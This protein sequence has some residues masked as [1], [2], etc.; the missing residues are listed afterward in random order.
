[1]PRRPEG[2]R[3]Y[4]REKSGQK[5][6]WEIR[7]A[8]GIRL[9]TG[10]RCREEAEAQLA[11]Y[12]E[13]KSRPTGPVN[14]DELS[15]SLC[16]SIYAEEHA[17]FVAAPERIGYAIEALDEFWR[18]LPVSSVTGAMC[19]RYAATRQRRFRDGRT[20][21]V[22]PGTIRR[23]LNVLQ[24]AINHCHGEGYLITAPKVTLP[25]RPDPV[26]RF[27]TRQEA[28]WLIRAAR[29]LR[30][31]GRHL[32]DFILHG[33]YTG[34]RKDTILGMHIDTPSVSGGH[35][36]TVR[37]ILY[38]KPMGK[39]ETKKR[40][41][42]ARLPPRYLA[43]L[44]RQAANGRRFVVQ[45]CDGHR[46]GDIRKGWARAVRLAE[47]LAAGQGIEIDLTM[48]DGKGGRKYITPHVLKHTAIT[49]AVQRG[50][51]LPDVASYFST[52]L[53]TIERVYWHHSP[54]HQRS[55]VEAMDRRK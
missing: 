53:E 29:N 10:T 49:W 54:D 11:A 27:L 48:P 19:R 39:A 36:D 33:L 15:I 20:A 4:W 21:P 43:H 50:A 23:E 42:P 1:M 13:R 16:L 34:S 32:A 40:Q 17:A 5:P 52:S 18:D 45:D 24:A 6:Y 44:R 12:I 22:S 55:A 41:R 28:A 9:S 30:R 46:V 31:D 7:D 38:R 8:G 47:E 3:L 25:P 35:V 26:E 14:P 2:A 51:F 37:G